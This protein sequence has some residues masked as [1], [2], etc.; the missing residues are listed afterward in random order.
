MWWGARTARKGSVLATKAVETHK[1]E[2]RA[3]HLA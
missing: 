1:A 3:S 2:A